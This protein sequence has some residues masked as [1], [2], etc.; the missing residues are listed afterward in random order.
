VG[1]PHNTAILFV[2]SRF[3]NDGEC[4]IVHCIAFVTVT[5]GDDDDD[6]MQITR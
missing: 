3:D 4:L 1:I 5:E 6:V 2:L